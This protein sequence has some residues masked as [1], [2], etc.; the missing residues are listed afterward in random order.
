MAAAAD[1]HG[2]VAATTSARVDRATRPQRCCDHRRR[3]RERA[4]SLRRGS[5]SRP[6]RARHPARGRATRGALSVT[7]GTVAHCSAPPSA[8]PRSGNQQPLAHPARRRPCRQPDYAPGRTSAPSTRGCRRSSAWPQPSP[9]R[10]RSG[11]QARSGH[12]RQSPSRRTRHRDRSRRAA[13]PRSPARR[14]DRR[15]R[16]RRTTTCHP[17]RATPPRSRRAP[18]N[19]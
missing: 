15:G 3:P 16:S 2:R 17:R 13:V 14:R 12:P 6:Q 8:A 10:I 9:P 11:R 4:T 7:T 19:A 18:P 5:L 1:A